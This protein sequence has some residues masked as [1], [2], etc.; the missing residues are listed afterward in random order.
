VRTG[1][2]DVR[3]VGSARSAALSLA[4]LVGWTVALSAGWG[5][6]ASVSAVVLSVVVALAG[7]ALAARV[8]LALA[9]PTPARVST[10]RAGPP[11]P[12][13]R[14][15]DPDRAGRARPRAPG[16]DRA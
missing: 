10:R 16:W 8:V 3:W 7:A 2:D 1:G 9:V 4:V 5:S 14:A 13:P 12:A 6:S 15:C 11:R